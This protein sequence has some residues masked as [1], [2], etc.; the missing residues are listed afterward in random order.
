YAAANA[1]LDAFARQRRAQGLPATSLAWG[2]W[3]GEGMSAGES[4]TRNERLGLPPM[5]P[6]RAVE[7]LAAAAGGEH[8]CTMVAD[9]RWDTY[10]AG[11][12]VRRPSPLLA[13]LTQDRSSSRGGSAWLR[14]V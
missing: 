13:G 12:A 10:A 6:A 14:R 2:P 5:D 4:G 9:V 11:F 8:P 7:A 3:A 1:W